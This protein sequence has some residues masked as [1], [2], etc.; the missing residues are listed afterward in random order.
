MSASTFTIVQPRV[1]LDDPHACTDSGDVLTVFGGL[2]DALARRGASGWEPNLATGWSM[3]DDARTTTFTL[4]AGVRFHDGE[5]CDAGAIR[6]CLERM[7]R[8]DMGATLGA[9][10]VYAQYLQGM[11]IDVPDPHTLVMTT[12]E[13]IA[14]ILDIV[15]YGHIV[16]PRAL[17]DAGEDLARRSVGTGPW[18]LESCRE[19]EHLLASASP[20]HLAPKSRHGELR[21]QAE[22][23]AAARL[24]AL[25]SGRAHVANGLPMAGHATAG[26]TF[27]DYLAPTALI[28]M[29]N[30][31]AGPAA[32]LRVR[33]AL[34]LAIDRAALVAGVLGGA[35]QPLHGY[36]SPA[37][38]GYD[39]AAPEFAL[40]RAE[41]RR[42][43]AEAGYADGLALNVYC[44]TRL[45]DEAP[46]LV[47][48]IEA[49]LSGIGVSFIRHVEPDRTR[50]ANQVRL[51]QI[52]D[53]CVFDSSPMS[54]FRVLHEKVDSRVKGSWWE[55]YAN[56]AVEALLDQARRTIDANARRALRCETYRLLQQDPPWLYV[57]NHRRR[58]G[59]A[60]S[61]PVYAM[62]FDGVLDVRTLPEL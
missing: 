24:D 41:A 14:D 43:L 2:F 3:S 6:F 12:A 18:K 60:G 37:H 36:I 40:D 1:M 51:K 26:V 46:Q 56:P 39:P 16:S 28:F 22:P 19:G 29:F 8:P 47:D 49:Q 25:M 33:R 38:D 35:G 32:D 54:A 7:A 17:A 53:I 58:I 57:Y 13:P 52:H 10:G 45:P 59:L 20:H 5:P 61:H 44:P 42:L 34:N 50:Y 27:H 30:A 23:S 21:W 31:A 4:R 62:R 48:A 11:R 9:P 55:G 15:G